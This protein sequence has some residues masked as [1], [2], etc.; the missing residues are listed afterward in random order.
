MLLKNFKKGRADLRVEHQGSI[1]LIRA[2]SRRGRAWVKEHV[3][4]ESW[5]HLGASIACDLRCAPDIA[6]GADDDGLRV[7]VEL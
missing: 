7:E 5:Q 3:Q 1:A 4:A 2:P 6:N